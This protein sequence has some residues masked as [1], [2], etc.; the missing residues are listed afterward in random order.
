MRE[1]LIKYHDVHYSSNIMSLVVIGAYPIPELEL[2]VKKHFEKI[3]NKDVELTDYTKDLGFD[4]AKG[5]VLRYLPLKA[6][7]VFTI[8]W[9]GFEST[10]KHGPGNALTYLGRVI[11]HKG[12]K[13]LLSYLISKD[14]ATNLMAGP[15]SRLQQ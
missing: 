9:E 10:H 8:K 14:L 12:H 6:T 11:G 5:C 2:M 4:P 7:K 15:S 3:K 1:A 13:N